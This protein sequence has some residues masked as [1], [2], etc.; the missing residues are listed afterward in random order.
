MDDVFRVGGG[1]GGSNLTNQSNDVRKRHPIMHPPIASTQRLSLQVFHHDEGRTIREMSEVVT[2][3]NARM[4]D[5]IH[6]FGFVKEAGDNLVIRREICMEHFDR[7]T[8]LD[9]IVNRLVDDSHSALTDFP[10]DAVRTDGV[11]NHGTPPQGHIL[12]HSGS[13]LQ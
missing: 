10:H 9:R 4:I 6:R 1:E 13:E 2:L 5:P 8:S 7:N 3:H 11:A 12:V